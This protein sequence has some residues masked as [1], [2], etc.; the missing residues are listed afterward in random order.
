[1]GTTK[2]ITDTDPDKGEVIEGFYRKVMMQQTVG[3]VQ[4][5]YTFSGNQRKTKRVTFRKIQEKFKEH[6][7]RHNGSVFPGTKG[8]SQVNA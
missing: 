4:K 5:M 8:D 1:M 6:Y 3:K 7:M 2:T